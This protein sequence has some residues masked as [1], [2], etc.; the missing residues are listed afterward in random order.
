MGKKKNYFYATQKA[1]SIGQGLAIFFVVFGLFSLFAGL[2]SGLW[3]M[4]IGWFLFSSAQ[5][6]YQRSTL[7]EILSG[8][9][10]KDIMVKDIVWLDP[11]I[12]LEDAV[13]RYFLHYGY[14]KFP[15]EVENNFKGS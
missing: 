2:P 13:N 14:G 5:A 15:V 11:S 10:V 4:L 6:S 7:Q 12:I 3:L 1:S 8:V 9:K